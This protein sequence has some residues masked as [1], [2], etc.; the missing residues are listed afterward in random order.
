MADGPAT[1]GLAQLLELVPCGLVMTTAGGLVLQVNGTM[2]EWTGYDRAQVE[3]RLRFVD[4]LTPGSRIYHESH[5]APLLQLQPNVREIALTFLRDDGTRFPALVSSR[6]VEGVGADGSPLVVTSVFEAVD[7]RRYEEELLHERRR[8]EDAGARLLLMQRAALRLALADGLTETAQVATRTAVDVGGV[9]VAALWLQDAEGWTTSLRARATAADVERPTGSEPPPQASGT[10]SPGPYRDLPVVDDLVVLTWP[11]TQEELAGVAAALASRTPQ[12]EPPDDRRAGPRA[13]VLVPVRDG[14][15][16][17]GLLACR[18]DDADDLDPVEA[19]AL[20]TIGHQAGLALVRALANEQQHAV[21]TT[22][23]HSLLPDHLP[24]SHSYALACVYQPGQE[25][26]QVGGDWYDAWLLD[27]GPAGR[28]RRR[29]RRPRHPR[30]GHDGSAAQRP[31]GRGDR[32][33]RPRGGALPA[34]PVR[35]VGAGG[36]VHDG[37]DGRARPVHRHA[38]VRVRR[39]PA[40]DPARAPAARCGRCGTVARCRSACARGP[41]ASRH[42][43][44]WPTGRRCCCTPTDWS[45]GAT[46]G[47][48][49]ASRSWPRCWPAPEA[50]RR[51]SGSTRYATPCS[52][53]CTRAWTTSACSASPSARPVTTPP[54]VRA[55]LGRAVMEGQQSATRGQIMRRLIFVAGVGVGYVLGSRAGRERYEQLKA[56]GPADLGA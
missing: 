5:Y 49:V 53:R 56:Q 1:T 7:R 15:R 25:G 23:Q 16:R 40:A 50:S 19:E 44:R 45:S 14:T 38:H 8:A 12:H 3:G 54:E 52:V 55:A 39:A 35:R 13:V 47:W 26:T 37:R 36:P 31:A 6:V 30:G 27:E 17:L 48:S 29:R 32:C 21:A 10:P 41:S 46:S 11:R 33:R 51:R 18:L 42:R 28:R 2:L 24:T 9:A 34:R 22:L 43:C 4:L 20:R